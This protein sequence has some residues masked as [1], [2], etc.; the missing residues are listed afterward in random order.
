M[1]SVRVAVD[2]GEAVVSGIPCIPMV[3][4]CIEWIYIMSLGLRQGDMASTLS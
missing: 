2:P 4:S 1:S 3:I